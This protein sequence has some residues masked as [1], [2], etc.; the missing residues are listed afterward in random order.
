VLDPGIA[1]IVEKI[2]RQKQQQTAREAMPL[3][4]QLAEQNKPAPEAAPGPDANAMNEQ[5]KAAHCSWLPLE[6]RSK[7]SDRRKPKP[8]ASPMVQEQGGLEA[9]S[10]PAMGKRAQELISATERTRTSPTPA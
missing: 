10:N 7:D 1:K 2:Q 8:H 9:V 4:R 5:V 6:G 3:L